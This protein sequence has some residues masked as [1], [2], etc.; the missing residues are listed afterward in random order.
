MENETP[1]L[2]QYL[3][4]VDDVGMAL[5]QRL[6]HGINFVEVQGMSM[7]DNPYHSFLVTPIA[8][9]PVETP[10]TDDTLEPKT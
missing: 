9:P 8:K 3:L 10:V 7:T 5:M 4:V 6:S 1:K 2:K